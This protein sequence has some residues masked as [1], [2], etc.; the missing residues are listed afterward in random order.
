M[1]PRVLPG[2]RPCAYVAPSLQAFRRHL[3]NYHAER[4]VVSESGDSRHECCITLAPEEVDRRRAMLA[5]GRGGRAAV[6]R[7][8][9]SQFQF[10][11]HPMEH[12]QYSAV[13]EQVGGDYQEAGY[14]DPMRSPVS[15][16][17]DGTGSDLSGDFDENLAGEPWLQDLDL[18][19]L[20]GA[21]RGPLQVASSSAV[22]A[23][24]TELP[25][26]QQADVCSSAVPVPTYEQSM[27]RYPELTDAAIE[28]SLAPPPYNPPLPPPPITYSRGVTAQPEAMDVTVNARPL[29]PP[30]LGLLDMPA[31]ELVRSLMGI[32]AARPAASHSQVAE[33]LAESVHGASGRQIRVAQLSAALGV[34]LLRASVDRLVQEVESRFGHSDPHMPLTVHHPYLRFR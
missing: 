12:T 8:M 33:A 15:S 26:V 1:C 3:V 4:L 2:G 25:A 32:M 7:Q 9:A 16:S 28:A 21:A 31:E 11:R 6:H 23:I 14:R 18:P 22:R 34:E 17:T 29:P 27:M 24:S 13:S 19:D 5:C 20:V 30:N 10:E